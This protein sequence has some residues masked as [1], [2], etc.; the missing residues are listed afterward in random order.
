MMFKLER[1]FVALAR[2]AAFAAL[3]TLA[4]PPALASDDHGHDHEAAP[5]AAGQA[6]PRFAASSELFEIVGVV[7]GKRLTLYVDRFEDNA[8]VKGAKVELELGGAKVALKEHADGEFEA[9]L[10]E[11]LKPGVTPVTATVVA[12]SDTDLLAADIDVHADAPAAPAHGNGGTQY[13]AWSAGALLVLGALAWRVRRALAARR[14][15][16]AA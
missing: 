1:L 12:G 11:T 2:L 16:G 8:P 5:A 6:L 13:F 10:A 7:D 4:T 9:T 14:V 15:G 3:A